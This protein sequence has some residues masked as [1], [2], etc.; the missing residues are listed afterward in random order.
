ME[1]KELFKK[2]RKLDL[3]IGKYVLF[4]S[5][6]MCIR[7]LRE[8]NDVDILAS[9]ELW[10]RYSAKPDWISAKAGSGSYCL[11]N[12]G[13]EMFKDWGPGE[14]NIEELIRDAEIIDRLPFARLEKVIE[15]KKLRAGEK[16][17]KDIEM[18]EKFLSK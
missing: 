18:I 9:L 3:P 2:V 4:G 12:G 13:M 17:L 10:D 1:N 5:A 16:D 11:Q 6:P 7:G 14:W 8:C 15:W